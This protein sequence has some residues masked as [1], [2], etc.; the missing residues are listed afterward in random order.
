M[1]GLTYEQK[2]DFSWPKHVQS[3]K[4]EQL[5]IQVVNKTL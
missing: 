1:A 3:G 2:P 5:A 4:V